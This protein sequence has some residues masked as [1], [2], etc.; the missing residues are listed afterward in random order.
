MS[1]Q[2]LLSIDLRARLSRKE[3]AS[4]RCEAV[5]TPSALPG[6]G[7]KLRIGIYDGSPASDGSLRHG[8]ATRR[9]RI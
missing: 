5:P 7:G 8:S 2:G 9:I 3:R 6:D 1:D 4:I